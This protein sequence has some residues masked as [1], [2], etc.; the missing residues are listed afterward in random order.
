MNRY[1]VIARE[2]I[3]PLLATVAAAFMVWHFVSLPASI[4]FWMLTLLVLFLFRDPERDI[5]SQPLAVVSPVDG[6]VTA[7]NH[8]NDPYLERQSIHVILQMNTYGVYT[9]RSPVEG[10]V[11]E[12][13][14]IPDSVDTP[15]GVWL[16]TDEGDDVV[17]VMN[18]GRLKIDPRCYIRI[19]E[20]IGQGKR[21]G[22]VPLGSRIE[23]YLPEEAR[24]VVAAGDM[25]RAGSDVIA[26]LVH[27]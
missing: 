20:R 1:S 10:K 5:P 8:V 19:G 9:A 18:K 25:V 3:V 26:K 13:S 27:G 21:C 6:R 11:L 12:P 7:I 4:F 15:H 2:G 22:F 17:M 24:I 23:L 16:K 14:C